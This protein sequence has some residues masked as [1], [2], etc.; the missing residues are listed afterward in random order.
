MWKKLMSGQIETLLIE[1]E[2]CLQPE[3]FEELLGE[4]ELKIADILE[5]KAAWKVRFALKDCSEMLW[6]DF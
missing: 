1:A 6:N 3:E 4:L 2:K 5:S